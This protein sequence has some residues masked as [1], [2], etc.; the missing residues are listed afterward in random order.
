MATPNVMPKKTNPLHQQTLALLL[1]TKPVTTTIKSFVVGEDGRAVKDAAGRELIVE[2]KQTRQGLRWP[3]A[4][5][6]SEANIERMGRR[7]L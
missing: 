1:A 7:W 6:V 2:T 4:Q 5:N 3:L